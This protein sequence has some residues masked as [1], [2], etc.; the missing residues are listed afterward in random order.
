MRSQLIVVWRVVEEAKTDE[1]SAK[2]LTLSLALFTAAL[3]AGS[4]LKSSKL[5]SDASE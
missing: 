3:E 4:E 1:P 2:R 5:T